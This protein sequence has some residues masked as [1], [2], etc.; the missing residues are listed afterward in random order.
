MKVLIAEDDQRLLELY[1]TFASGE[2]GVNI[3]TARNGKEVLS[4]LK[5]EKVDLLL[6]DF[7]MPEMDGLQV[8][9]QLHKEGKTKKMKIFL[10][11]NLAEDANE[12]K[13]KELGACG[14]I[15]KSNI[16]YKTIKHLITKGE[17]LKE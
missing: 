8:L 15:I 12:K 7:F 2:P 6:L 9:E 5:K 10:F 13:A 14:Y 4:I 17:V 16:S 11:T 3:L 1:Q